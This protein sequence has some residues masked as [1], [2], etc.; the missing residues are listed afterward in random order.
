VRDI[1]SGDR[2]ILGDPVPWFSAHTITHAQ[3]DLHVL[4]GC[5]II[6]CFLGSLGDGQQI[7]DLAEL[8]GV[9]KNL[10]VDTF[11]YGVLNQPTEHDALLASLSTDSLGF[12]MDRDFRISRMFGAPGGLRTVVVDPMLRVIANIGADDP[13]GHTPMLC[14][15]LEHLPR[16]AESAG[17]PLTA[18]VLIV[19][20]VFEFD[21]CDALV[22]LYEELGGV[23][24]GFQLD[25]RGKT[26]TVIDHR[27]KRRQDLVLSD[28][29]L[30]GPLRE[31]II[32]RLLPAIQQFFQFEA[33]RMDRY[34][35]SCYDAEIGGHFTRHRDNVNAG[36]RHRRFAVS[37]NLNKDYDGCD[38]V[39]P[40]FGP[41]RYRA[42]EGGAVVFSCGMLHEVT[43]ITRGRRYAFIPFLYNDADARL[44]TANNAHLQDGEAH[45]VDGYDRLFPP[46]AQVAKG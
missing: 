37:I 24:S 5:W 35:V 14:G 39:F 21:L 28:E 23:D 27:M 15:L 8:L 20:R 29:A 17:V 42:P 9:I 32:R 36:A 44:R 10:G 18:P 26:A 12:I 4:A 7:S 22:A 40:E 30:R 16:P 45:Y 1:E 38:L 33:T 46:E 34:M 3:V 19:P 11:V 2:I 41:T 31:R 13:G 43:P 6:L 25:H